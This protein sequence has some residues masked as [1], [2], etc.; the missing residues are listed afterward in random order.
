MVKVVQM[1]KKLSVDKPDRFT[2]I[3]E[4]TGLRKPD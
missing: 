1:L 4:E 2:H 3:H